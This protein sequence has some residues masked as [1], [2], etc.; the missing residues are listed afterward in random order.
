[1]PVGVKLRTVMVATIIVVLVI[2]GYWA[3]M[4]VM[5]K[6]DDIGPE[7]DPMGTDRSPIAWGNFAVDVGVDNQLFTYDAKIEGWI[8]TVDYYDTTQ[9]LA[10]YERDRLD[11][12]GLWYDDI[13][14]EMVC[15]ITGPG[16]FV[17]IWTEEYSIEL[18]EIGYNW[19][20]L[21][22]G[23]CDFWDKGTYTATVKVYLDGQD[24]TGLAE[25]KIFTFT[26]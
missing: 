12:L 16:K 3:V 14:V 22:S 24:F 1:M 13:D 20:H 26:V 9:K 23:N 7:E 2:V 21:Q 4:G 17:A 6:Q 18:G 10:V 8:A 19:N 25:S 15:E 5:A 11:L